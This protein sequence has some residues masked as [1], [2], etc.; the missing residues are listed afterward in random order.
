LLGRRQELDATVVIAPHHG[1]RTSSTAALVAATSPEWVVFAAGARN[2]WGF[3]APEVA[4]RWRR[5]GAQ[6]LQTGRDGAI[7]FRFQPER[8][9]EP[10]RERERNRRIWR[11]P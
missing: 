5:A 1:S 8:P 11:E 9:P 4:A 3:P 2:R 7:S 6:T 10:T